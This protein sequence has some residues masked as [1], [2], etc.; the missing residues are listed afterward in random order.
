LVINQ[1]DKLYKVPTPWFLMLSYAI[2][3]IMANW[4]DAR[5]VNIFGIITDAGTLIFPLTFLFSNLITEVYGYKFARQAIWLGFLF[6]ILFLAYGQIVIHLPNPPYP[7]NNYLF[8]AIL[9]I[10]VRIIFASLVSYLC[11][12]PL[13][14]F[15]LA[16]LKIKSNGKLM[17]LRFLL[18]TIVAAGFDSFI[19]GGL[20]FYYTLTKTELLNLILTMWLIKVA[21]EIIGLPASLTLTYKLKRYAK[22]D[23]FDKNTK[24]N[25]FKL[26]T[27]YNATDNEYK[28]D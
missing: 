3:L 18:S 8:D 16:K 7:T 21:V 10:N 22:L 15:L 12:E 27:K 24:F 6:N 14:I 25:L 19:F 5:L 28:E 4:F 11:S 23:I 17:W 26:E 13:N 9:S 20:A 1:Q 2:V